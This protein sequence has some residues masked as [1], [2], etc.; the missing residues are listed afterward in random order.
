M[1]WKKKNEKK[2]KK[3][4]GVDEIHVHNAHGHFH[5]PSSNSFFPPPL[6]SLY[7]FGEKL[8]SGFGKNTLNPIISFPSPLSTKYFLKGFSYLFSLIFLFHH[9]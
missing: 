8:F 7:F 5:Q 6:F 2:R 3:A 1:W 4:F 9:L